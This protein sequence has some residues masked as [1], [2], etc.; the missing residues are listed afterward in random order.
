MGRNQCKKAENTRNQNA[1]PPTG[2]RSSSLSREQSLTE[3]E[4]DDLTESGFRRW[5]IRNFCELKEHILTQCKETKNLERRFNKMLTRMDNLEKNISEL[6]ELKNTTRELH[7]ACTKERISEV[8]DQFNEIKREGKIR[9]KRVKRNEQSLQEIWDYVKRP[10]LRLIGVPECGEE[11]ESKLENTLQ[12]II[13]ENFPNLTRQANIQVQEIQRTPQ[14]YSSRRATP[15]HIIVRFTRVEMKEK[16]LRAAR[17]KGRVTHKGKPIRLTADLSAETLQARREISLLPRLECSGT[18]SAH[19]QPLP[20]GFKQVSCFSL[21]SSWDCRRSLARSPGWSTVAQSRLTATSAS[22]VQAILH[23]SL[24]SSCDHRRVPPCP[25]NFFCIFS[26]DGVSP[27]WPGWSQSLDLVI[28]PPRP[29]KVLGLQRNQTSISQWVPV[30]SRLIPVSPTQGQWGR[31]LSGTSQSVLS[32]TK[33]TAS[34]GAPS[35][36]SWAFPGSAVLALSSALPI[37][38]LL[39]GM[40]PA[41]PLGTE[42]HTLR[43]EKRRTGQ[44]SRAGSPGGSFTGN[45]PVCGHQKFVCNCGVHLLSALSLGATILS[46]CYVAILDL[47]PPVFL[48]RTPLPHRA[49]PSWVRCACCE[50]LS[51]Q[52]FQ[53][54]FSLWGWDQLSPS[55]PY[56][57]HQEAPRWGTGKT[58]APAKR[59]ALATRMESHSVAQAGVQWH[60]LGSPQPP[61]PG[62]KQFSSL[63]LLNSWDYSR[64]RVLPFGEQAGLKLLTSSDSPILASQSAGNIDTEFLLYHQAGVQWRD[65]GSPQPCLLG[66]SD[67]IASASQVAG[68]TGA[69]NH[70]WLI[71]CI[72]VEMGFRHIGQDGLSLLTSNQGQAPWLTPVIPKFWEA[73]AGRSRGQEI[74][75]IPANLSRSPGEAVAHPGHC[76]P[77]KHSPASASR[78]AGTTGPPPRPANFCFSRDGVPVLARRSRSLDLVIHPPRPPKRWGFTM[79]ARLVLNSCPQVIH[80]PGPTKVLELQDPALAHVGVQ[81]CNLGSLQLPPP[82]SSDPL[83]SVSRMESCYVA[84]AGVQ[85]HDNQFTA[86]SISSSDSPASASR[87]TGI[88]V[89]MGFHHV[90][91]AGFKLFTS[92]DPPTLASQSAGIAEMESCCVAQSSLK[93]LASSSPLTLTS[94]SIWPRISQCQACGGSEQIPGIDIQ[95]SRKYHDTHKVESC[96]VSQAGVQ[97]HDL[98]SLQPPPP[99]FKRF[100]CLSLLSSWDY[101]DEVSSYWPGCS[102]TSDLM[103]CPPCPPKLSTTKD[104]PQPVEEKVGALTKII[105]AMGFTGP[106]KYSKWAGHGAPAP[107][108]FFFRFRQFSCLA[109]LGPARLRLRLIFDFVDGV[110]PVESC[111]VARLECNGAILAHCILCLLGSS[112]S[113]ASASQMLKNASVHGRAHFPFLKLFKMLLFYSSRLLKSSKVLCFIDLALSPRLECSGTISAHCQLRLPGSNGVSIKP[114]SVGQAGLELLTSVDPPAS[115]S[116]SLALSLR[117]EYSGVISACYNFCLL[118][119]ASHLS[120]LSSVLPWKIKIAALRMYTSCVEKT[121]FEEFFLSSSN[122]TA[123]ASLIAEIKGI[124]HHTQLLFV[125]LVEMEFYHECSGAILVHCY[126]HLPGSSDSCASAFRVVGTTVETGFGYVGQARLKL[127]ASRDPLTLASQSHGLGRE[128]WCLAYFETISLC[129]LGWKVGSHYIAQADLELLVLGLKQSC[130]RFPKCRDYRHEPPCPACFF[131]LSA[132]LN[133]CGFA[134]SLRLQYSDMIL[135]HCNLCSLAQAIVPPQPPKCSLTLLPRL[136]CSGKIAAF[137]NLHLPGSSDSRASAYRR[138]SFTLVAQAGVQ[139]WDLGSLQPLPPGF[140]QFS[141]LSLLSSWDSRHAP[142]CLANFVFLVETEFLLVDQADLELLTKG[143]LPASAS[144]SAGITAYKL[145]CGRN[146]AKTQLA[147]SEDPERSLTIDAQAAVQWHD[148]GS[149][150]PPPSRFKQFFCL[151]L[152]SS[153]DYRCLPPHPANFYIF[154]R[155]EGLALSP[156]LEYSGTIIAHCSLHFWGSS[157]S[158]TSAS[159]VAGTTVVCHCPSIE[160][161]FHQIVQASLELLS[162]GGAPSPQSWAFPGSAVLVLGPQCFQLLFSLWGWDQPSPTKRASSPVQSAP[163]SAAPAKRVTLATHLLTLSS[164]SEFSTTIIAHCSLDLPGSSNLPTSASSVAGT[165]DTH[166]HI[167]LIFTFFGRAGT[168]GTHYQ[169]QLIFVFLVEMGFHHVGQAGLLISSDPPTLASQSAGINSF[170]VS[171]RLKCNEWLNLDSLQPLPLGFKQFSCLS[172]PSS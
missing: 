82:G 119:S 42:S 129:R 50:T 99:G 23:L 70:V 101:R 105:E 121:D 148:L 71:F 16:M 87:V 123:S 78:V 169:A 53:L 141:C 27:C 69:C 55:I 132:L 124:C 6:M 108:F 85:W 113:P 58:A 39:V 122:S 7:E 152:P 151:S 128:P 49:G 41:E 167:R 94:E 44:K 92:S 33:I 30:C 29:P 72:L 62:F 46:C 106:L 155:D 13:Q 164:R 116:Q 89:E 170:A 115:A 162:S 144:Q 86:T 104:S 47:S 158:P 130:L 20:P 51:P 133:S 31:A 21:L 126:F 34:G 157:D 48:W 19:L 81:W 67:S 154:S 90:G 18:V 102:Q 38:V 140:K 60:N 163:R 103:I 161:R 112:S 117:L 64:D 10:N 76:N 80:L 93:P 59:V 134:L 24:L 146:K 120:L 125:F 1:S 36:Q 2:D 68:T 160:M 131:S 153:W 11:N 137:Y 74:E 111:S 97:W 25:A 12:D 96:S 98:G 8:E 88:T 15:R 95:L 110:S 57:P 43:T 109:R 138:R 165:T 65:L 3:N 156:R 159:Q 45:L 26:R 127:L 139:W 168:T 40:G 52:R 79:L 142:P 5:I 83:T 63:S 166:H 54:L 147:L 118:G 17:E 150:Q 143:D 14:R 37:A 32:E 145:P 73:K 136:E 107:P 91:Q 171:P 4:C 28:R 149:L 135:A 84:Q 114:V 61:P 100:F 35:P 56:T 172:L 77:V 75:T 9:E 66:S 22:W